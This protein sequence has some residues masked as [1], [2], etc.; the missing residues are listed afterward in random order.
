MGDPDLP[1]QGIAGH[2]GAGGVVENKIGRRTEIGEGI[3]GLVGETAHHGEEQEPDGDAK[4]PGVPQYSPSN[5]SATKVVRRRRFAHGR[6]LLDREAATT[7]SPR[8][9]TEQ[10]AKTPN[11]VQRPT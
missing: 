6:H 10:T 1:A 8:D 4:T 11:A 5:R 3:R 2:L 9:R 7:A